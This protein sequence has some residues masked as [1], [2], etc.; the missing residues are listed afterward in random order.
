MLVSGFWCFVRS[1]LFSVFHGILSIILPDVS[2]RPVEE[3]LVGMEFVFQQGAA[4]GL[5]DFPLA[6]DCALPAV[7]SHLPNDRVDVGDDSFDD[8]MGVAALDFVE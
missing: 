5:F 7:E 6:L 8:D 1:E 4:E 2:I 3:V